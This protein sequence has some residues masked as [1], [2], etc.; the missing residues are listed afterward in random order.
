MDRA[1]CQ[2]RTEANSHSSASAVAGQLTLL[3][4]QPRCPQSL[5]QICCANGPLISAPMRQPRGGSCS[6]TPPSL[7]GLP[8]LNPLHSFGQL[9]LTQRSSRQPS[10]ALHSPVVLL[11]E[12]QCNFRTPQ[13]MAYQLHQQAAHTQASCVVKLGL[14]SRKWQ[15]HTP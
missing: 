6:R 10:P 4:R 9:P 2:P 13:M 3:M 5:A 1:C 8:T 14:V 12:V 15:V 11:S 7:T